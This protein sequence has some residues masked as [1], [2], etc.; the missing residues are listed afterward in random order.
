MRGLGGDSSGR[1]SKFGA[2]AIG[3]PPSNAGARKGLI[4]LIFSTTR[5]KSGSRNGDHRGGRQP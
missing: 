2:V 4:G 5:L 3:M 1:V